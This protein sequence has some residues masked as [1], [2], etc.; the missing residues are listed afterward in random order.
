MSQKI[1]KIMPRDSKYSLVSLREKGFI[2]G[3][4][5]GQSLKQSIAIQIPLTSL[6]TIINDTTNMIFPLELEGQTYNCI[7]RAFQPDHLHSKI[8]HVDFQFVKPGEYIKMNIPVNYEGLELLRSKKYILEKAVSR[9]LVKGSV[10]VLP[11]SFM[12]N[13]GSLDHGAKI[14]VHNI[15]LPHGVELLMNPE[16][17]IATV[18]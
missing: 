8:L 14:F 9:I 11:E 4:M 5:Y 2:P 15:E 18:Q 13:V 17:I 1:F 10:D 12:F 6:Q 7:L 3:I 16:T